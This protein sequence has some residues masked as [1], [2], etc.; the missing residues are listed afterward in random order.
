MYSTSPTH[1]PAHPPTHP[2]TLFYALDYATMAIGS[3]VQNYIFGT[4]SSTHPPTHPPTPLPTAP[5]S[6]RLLLLYPSNPTP[7]PTPPPT[8]PGETRPD[9]SVNFNP[10]LGNVM[11]RL[12]NVIGNPTGLLE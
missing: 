7:P 1:P 5:H 6:N 3:R 2:Q 10:Y 8:H 11:S 9:Q 4:S 12:T